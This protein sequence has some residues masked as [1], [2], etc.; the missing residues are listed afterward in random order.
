MGLLNNKTFSDEEAIAGEK[1][2]L[3]WGENNSK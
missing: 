1:V 2:A 3:E